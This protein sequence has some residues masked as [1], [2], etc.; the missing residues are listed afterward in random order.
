MVAGV[1]LPAEMCEESELR[2]LSPL[3]ERRRTEEVTFRLS[4]ISLMRGER[5]GKVIK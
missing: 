2:E 4:R 5:S 1:V 3:S